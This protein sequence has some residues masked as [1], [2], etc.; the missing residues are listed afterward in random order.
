MKSIFRIL[1]VFLTL[2]IVFGTVMFFRS[3]KAS[4]AHSYFEPDDVSERLKGTVVLCIGSPTAY[5]NGNKTMIDSSN[6]G[7]M[8][9]VKNNTILVPVRFIVESLGG[10]VEWD[11]TTR[12]VKISLYDKMINIRQGS[13]IATDATVDCVDEYK[14]A[15]PVEAIGGRTYVPLNL[16]SDALGGKIAEKNMGEDELIVITNADNNAEFLEDEEFVSMILENMQ[17]LP[18]VGSYEKLM[19]LL[20]SEQMQEFYGKRI[21][22]SD[23]N[24]TVAETAVSESVEKQS[25]S[26]SSED[27]NSAI[28]NLRGLSSEVAES[29]FSKTNVQVEGV[30]EADVV[31]TDGEYIYQV[32]KNRVVIAKAYPAGEMKV[33]NIIN[34]RETNFTPAEIYIHKDDTGEKL[35]VIGNSYVDYILPQKE[36]VIETEIKTEVDDNANKAISDE[37]EDKSDDESAS[38]AKK[39]YPPIYYSRE[40]VKTIVFDVTD[41]ANIKEVKDVEIDG[42]YISSRKIGPY[43]YIAS[44]KNIDYYR[45]MNVIDGDLQNN[46]SNTS[47]S[48]TDD[49]AGILPSYRYR[50][51]KDESRGTAETETSDLKKIFVNIGYDSIYYFPGIIQPNYLIIASID[52]N[53][54]NEEPN[55]SAYLGSG[56]N[57]YM[58]LQNLYVSITFLRELPELDEQEENSGTST[59]NIETDTKAVFRRQTTTENTLIYKFALNKENVVFK[60][61]GEVPG[62]VLNQF[63]MDEYNN[64]FRIA[65]TRG[66]VWGSGE[67]VSKNNVYVLDDM[68]NVIGKVE[69]IAPG[70]QIYSAR[71]MGDRAYMVTF[72]TVDPLFVIDLEDPKS[73][74]ILGALKIPGYSDYI[75]PYDENHIIGFGK[76]TVEVKDQAYYLGMKVALFD[77]TDVSNPVQKFSEI[78]GDRGTESELLGN[79]K[80]LLF[81]KEKGIMAFPVTVMEIKGE[82]KFD[83]FG[84]PKYGQFAFQGAYVYEIDTE[85]GFTLKGRI[86]HLSSDDYLKA[87][88]DW[89][90]ND[91]NIKRILYIKDM[92]YTLSNKMIKANDIYTLEEKNSIVIPG[93]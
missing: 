91:G 5:A 61:K 43:V 54:V 47:A 16:F 62:R 26:V 10:T 7:I 60:G 17:K 45:I 64:M 75:H 18:S 4:G 69:D 56:Q 72:R 19:E 36:A 89:Y 68:L 76:D 38:V 81:S 90:E 85:K 44:N 49:S 13:D 31:K 32:N 82:S 52:V 24:T 6:S 46:T 28:Q 83:E 63:S 50:N 71:F 40:I 92:L 30:D 39:I 20:T 51:V 2:V 25:G 78:I 37:A 79:H 41:K 1:S 59:E 53:E 29:D 87:G 74:K 65:T 80:A 27:A 77:V 33:E 23:T 86:T 15:I 42:Y 22:Y 67:F 66:Q 57:I 55:V 9:A 34:F 48:S 70:E 35:V 11:G 12:S 73:P 8:P 58:S 88:M 14:L 84:Y 3:E 21:F 93:N